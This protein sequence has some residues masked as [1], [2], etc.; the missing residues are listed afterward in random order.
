MLKKLKSYFSDQSFRFAPIIKDIFV[1][2]E[3]KKHKKDVKIYPHLYP[4]YNF[5]GKIKG[6]Y[7]I[8]CTSG[9]LLLTNNQ[10]H[11]IS[12]Y[13]TYGISKHNNSWYVF[14][15]TGYYG[16]IISFKFRTLNI[17]KIIF[18]SQKL[19]WTGL[20][21]GVHQI[22]F[23][24]QSLYLTDTNNNRIMIITKNKKDF[25]YPK[26]KGSKKTRSLNNNHFNSIFLIIL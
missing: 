15:K 25:F 10:I 17:N 4:S 11:C 9:L 3:N 2:I 20:S 26:D 1:A 8:G 21:P 16:R 23:W 5:Q 18:E 13:F 12:P 22:D 19:V 7:L 6:S 24:D 14:Q